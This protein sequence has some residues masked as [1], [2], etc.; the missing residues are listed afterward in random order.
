MKK[1]KNILIIAAALILLS[2]KSDELLQQAKRYKEQKNYSLAIEMYENALNQSLKEGDNLKTKEA[3]KELG[4]VHYQLKNYIKSEW[5]FDQ[6][7]KDADCDAEVLFKYARLQQINGRTD[8]AIDFY[9]KWGEKTGNTALAKSYTDF[10]E[11]IKKGEGVDNT[12]EV[13]SMGFNTKAYAEYSGVVNNGKLVYTSN[14][15]GKS[16]GP[17]DNTGNYFTDLYQSVNLD[18]RGDKSSSLFSKSLKTIYNESSATFSKDGKTVYF[19]GNNLKKTK[20]S[21]G[22]KLAIFKSEF[23]GFKWSKPKK[24]DFIVNGYNYAFPSI[25]ADGLTLFFSSDIPNGAGGMDIYKS[26]L[27]SGKWGTPINL[28]PNVNS[29]NNEVY[30]FL[31]DNGSE[32]VLYFS[33]DG[34]PGYG[35]LDIFSAAMV[36]GSPEAATILNSPIN[37]SYDDFG[38]WASGSNTF[39]YISSNRDG[40]DDVFYFKKSDEIITSTIEKKVVYIEKRTE[41]E[42]KEPTP[43]IVKK[44]TEVTEQEREEP[45][46]AKEEIITKKEED[47]A[48]VPEKEEP[49]IT[50]EEPPV[51]IKKQEEPE[52][53]KKETKPADIKKEEKKPVKEKAKPSPVAKKKKETLKENKTDSEKKAEPEKTETPEQETAGTKSIIEA[54]TIKSYYMIVYSA[55]SLY[56]IKKMRDSKYKDAEIIHSENDFYLIAYPLPGDAD[57]ANAKFREIG[58]KYPG[59]WFYFPKG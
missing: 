56:N 2:A 58:K 47:E 43:E 14:K 11:L 1:M 57:E 38:Y 35:G 24:V 6:L 33:T 18:Y 17:K 20:E 4:M 39:G 41:E 23:D 37:S 21:S 46:T 27:S 31:S 8:R 15:P 42:K 51:T 48:K 19:T 45:K 25:S 29:D 53:T 54:T 40:S 52:I 28:G 55:Y 32:S 16:L 5:Y 13:N 50:K 36:S 9:T 49:E 26:E 12:I 44:E 30:P 22:Y 59:A 34:K 10:C 3:L 7:V